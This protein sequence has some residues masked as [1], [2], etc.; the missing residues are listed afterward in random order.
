MIESKPVFVS[1][2]WD[3]IRCIIEDLKAVMDSIDDGSTD[4]HEIKI[5]IARAIAS[6]RAEK[7]MREDNRGHQSFP[8]CGPSTRE[9]YVKTIT[10]AK[11]REELKAVFEY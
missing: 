8:S 11:L 6:M 4:L 2:E 10:D 3:D 5:E 1:I 7:S 9:N